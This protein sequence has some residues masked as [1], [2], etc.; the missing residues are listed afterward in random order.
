MALD[1]SGPSGESC[2]AKHFAGRQPGNHAW[3]LRSGDRPTGAR[4]KTRSRNAWAALLRPANLRASATRAVITIPCKN[5]IDHGAHEQVRN[6]REIIF[7]HVPPLSFMIFLL[8]QIEF[9]GG[10]FL[11]AEEGK[12]QFARGAAK[13]TLIK[14]GGRLY[15]RRYRD[16]LRG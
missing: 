11:L 13:K 15:G 7:H 14:A 9:P 1:R 3:H 6:G 16:P 8:D 4:R 2:R 12:N 10:Q 5:A